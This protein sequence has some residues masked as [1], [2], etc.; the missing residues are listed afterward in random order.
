MKKERKMNEIVKD[1][2][3]YKLNGKEATIVN[4]TKDFICASTKNLK[5]PSEVENNSVN[6]TVTCIEQK[7]FFEC[8]LNSVVLPQNIK[9]IKLSAFDWCQIQQPLELPDSLETVEDWAFSS[10]RYESLNIPA[11]LKYIGW[12]AFHYNW[13]L[14]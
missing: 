11:N 6:Y 12:R 3:V 1:D 4:R 13:K 5:L 2:V 10:N 8:S 7:A 14:V 9:T